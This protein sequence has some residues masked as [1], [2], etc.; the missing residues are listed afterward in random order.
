MRTKGAAAGTAT[1][2]AFNFCVVEI[3]PIGIQTLHWKFYIIWTI[4]NASFVPLVYFI[5]PETAGRSLEDIE[6][7]F[8]GNPSLWVWKDKEVTK[9][10][11]PEKYMLKEEEDVRRASSADAGAWR[12][13]SR[14]S[15]RGEADVD[16]KTERGSVEHHKEVI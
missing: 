12:R 11:R 9:S 4:L 2:W 14:I 6:E 13:G 8:R 15:Y 3:T 5:Y 7:Y 16:E 10:R 1:N